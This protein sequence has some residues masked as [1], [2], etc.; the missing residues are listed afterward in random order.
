M[1]AR[2]SVV[3][4]CVAYTPPSVR[5]VP[6]SFDVGG[7]PALSRLIERVAPSFAGSECWVLSADVFREALVRSIAAAR[8]VE[9][10]TTGSCALQQV[11]RDFCAS[12]R[13]A[14]DLILFADAAIV[15]DCVESAAMLSRHQTE[16]ADVTLPDDALLDGVLPIIVNVSSVPALFTRYP[17]V[18][19][20]NALRAALRQGSPPRDVRTLRYSPGYRLDGDALQR[21]PAFATLA[22]CWTRSA[23]EHAIATCPGAHDDRAARAFKQRLLALQEDV[24][25]CTLEARADAGA[26]VLFSSLRTAFSGGEQ[27]L[28]TLIAHLDSTRYAPAA[29]LPFESLLAERL[30]DTGVPTH[31]A[32]WDYS[33][34]TGR[35]LRFCEHVLD[36]Y[37]P[38][39]VHIDAQPN[40][41]LMTVAFARKIPIVGHLRIIP[42]DDISPFSYLPDR[43]IAISENVAAR[44]CRFNV[45]SERVAIVRNAVRPPV[46]GALTEGLL[47]RQLGIAAG[48]CVF[49][50]VSRISPTKQLDTAVDAFAEVITSAPDTHMVIV[51]E[52][53]AR[54]GPYA[55]DDV[56]Y[57]ESLK[58][59]VEKLGLSPRISWLGF[60]PDI[61]MLYGDIDCLVMCNPAEPLGR[62]GIEAL[63]HGVPVIGPS[64]GGTVE[65]VTD[66][67]DGL[68]FEA[69]TIGELAS[70]MRRIAGDEG[71]R[72]MLGANG[73]R[74]AERF[75]VERHVSAVQAVYDAVGAAARVTPEGSPL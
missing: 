65:I 26:R 60:E 6:W 61:Q 28:W 8:G 49:A 2:T 10:F 75:S 5:L 53:S 59:R 13:H 14:D 23:A 32:G 20:V 74:S 21:L 1:K 55:Q 71:L 7:V 11:L 12:R 54:F 72:R 33:L 69:G 25:R 57:A 68:L 17:Q 43:I 50:V 44:L 47:R 67:V 36:T 34:P 48:T 31:V 4:V 39:I 45:R 66:G 70:A 56:L 63:A 18:S 27:S 41:A 35:N 40:P 64:A 58:R 24:P 22:D 62:C 73:R 16:G 51:G 52:P 3:A 46:E 19:D 30:R 42:Q 9:A 38:D 29:I 37:R 15:P